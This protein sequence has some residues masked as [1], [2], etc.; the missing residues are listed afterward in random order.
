MKIY[1]SRFEFLSLGRIL[2]IR[3]LKHSNKPRKFS[4]EDPLFD[5]VGVL[6]KNTSKNA[7]MVF[8]YIF[9]FHKTIKQKLLKT[10]T[11]RDVLQEIIIIMSSPHWTVFVLLIDAWRNI[12]Y[13]T[14]LL[15]RSSL[16]DVSYMI[17]HRDI[18]TTLR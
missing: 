8:S 7:S 9:I 6:S 3:C 10:W 14:R 15:Q 2:E 18:K 17:G 1:H 11:L 13:V 5:F 12:P 16:Q 4:R